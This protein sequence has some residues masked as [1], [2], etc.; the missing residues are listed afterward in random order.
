MCD[1]QNVISFLDEIPVSKQHSPRWDA[2]RLAN[3]QHVHFP[4]ALWTGCL[5]MLAI[6]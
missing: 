2:V 1:F 3:V 4:C 6:G 5:G